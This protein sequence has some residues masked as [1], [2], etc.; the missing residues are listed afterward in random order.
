MLLYDYISQRFVM[1]S[2]CGYIPARFGFAFPLCCD[3]F[4]LKCCCG[5]IPA[6]FGIFVLYTVTYSSRNVVFSI[7]FRNDVQWNHGVAAVLLVSASFFFYIATLSS[8]NVAVAT[9]PTRFGLF[10]LS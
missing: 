7:V 5:C 3:K 1:E 4:I 10:I 9:S 6:R 2:C 8:R